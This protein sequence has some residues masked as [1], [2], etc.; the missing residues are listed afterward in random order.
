MC[1]PAL[2]RAIQIEAAL[3]AQG[4]AGFDDAVGDV[5]AIACLLGAGWL[6]SS[7][8]DRFYHWIIGELADCMEAEL[9]R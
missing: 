1:V 7:E 4:W 6:S 5:M 2:V 9:E 8:I 3:A